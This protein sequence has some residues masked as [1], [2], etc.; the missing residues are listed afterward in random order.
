MKYTMIGLVVAG[1][2]YSA[3]ASTHSASHV[4]RAAGGTKHEQAQ[5][6]WNW[7]GRVAAGRTV[8]IHGVNGDVSAEPASGNE[9]EVTA[10]KH[11]RRSDPDD[12]RIEVVEH[13]GGVTI[14]ALYPNSRG[15]Q[16]SCGVNGANNNNVNNNDVQ[17]DF[18]VRVPR[19]VHFEGN[20]VNGDVEATNLDGNVEINTVN[21]GAQLET[22][23]GE[24]H[25]T[26][27]NGSVTATVRALG[28]A[29]MKFET[30]N[31]GITVTLPQGL[32]ADLDAETVN[33]SIT[34]DFPISVQG[35]LSPRH[36]LGRIGQ[37]GRQLEMET[38]N[39]SIRIRQ[40]P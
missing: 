4:A 34:S 33:G 9:V 11:G 20:T 40:L 38:V 15:R 17:V 28:T 19:G 35:R 1:V 32:S 23:G 5:D 36:L 2:W 29:N 26:T 12:V 31:G 18:V 39:G 25:A 13:D 7:H 22:S 21:G 27:V 30:V 10:D 3:S 37:G 8:A 24:A 16:T 14:C 6:R